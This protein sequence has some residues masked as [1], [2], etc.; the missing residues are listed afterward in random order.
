MTVQ[1]SDVVYP[2]V[3]LKSAVTG[4]AIGLEYSYDPGLLKVIPTAYKWIP[5]GTLSDISS[6]YPEAVW[7]S[8]GAQK[9]SR[10]LF[11]LAF[12]IL[13]LNDFQKNRKLN[14]PPF[15]WTSILPCL[16]NK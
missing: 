12:R 6:P 7:A 15:I 11:L 8:D 3:L 1:K 9:I 13:N 16:S 5:S 4:T 14:C 2:P 10:D